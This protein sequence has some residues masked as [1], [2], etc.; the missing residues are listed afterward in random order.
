MPLL[1]ASPLALPASAD[2]ER[3][4]EETIHLADGAPA[5]FVFR[6]TPSETY[7]QFLV[8]FF[9]FATSAAVG[10]R[11]P[12][13]QINDNNHAAVGFFPASVGV[14]PSTTAQVS[15][16]AGVGQSY[17]DGL[18][19]LVIAIPALLLLPGYGI[20]YTASGFQAADQIT[21]PA[22]TYL[23]IPSGA[24]QTPPEPLMPTPA[25]V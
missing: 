16:V 10:T 21:S 14:G 25:L 19:H 18:G 22:M 17:S 12:V 6:N 24:P 13:V 23:R 9:N 3:A 11:T 2:L 7:E 8:G 1:N 4:Y 5:T 15:V 20:I